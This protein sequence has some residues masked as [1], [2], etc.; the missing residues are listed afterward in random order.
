M[1][2]R[3]LWPPAA[4]V[5]AGAAALFSQGP[6]DREIRITAGANNRLTYRDPQ[7]NDA[8]RRAARRNDSVTWVC[9]TLPPGET[10][11]G[12]DVSFAAR[13]PFCKNNC[14]QDDAGNDNNKNTRLTK[15][16][17]GAAAAGLYKYAVAVVTRNQ[18]GVLRLYLDDPEID[19][20]E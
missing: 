1:N 7:G 4:L 15:R 19:I 3:S 18:Q 16:V 11:A 9:C 2:L 8:T 12:F 10:F 6:Q 13:T 17:R 5:V 14:A 20:Q